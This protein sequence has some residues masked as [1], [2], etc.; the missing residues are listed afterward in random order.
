M[1]L[2]WC[3]ATTGLHNA[4]LCHSAI[5]AGVTPAVMDGVSRHVRP[6]EISRSILHQRMMQQAGND[7][8][9]IAE[10]EPL[11]SRR[12]HNKEGVNHFENG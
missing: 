3:T 7:V 11:V 9:Q 8:G 1:G 5:K 4:A 6:A 10:S 2:A 12:C